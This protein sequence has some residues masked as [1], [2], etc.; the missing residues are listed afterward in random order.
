MVYN[1]EPKRWAKMHV[2]HPRLP[3]EFPGYVILSCRA[4]IITPWSI[5]VDDD[6]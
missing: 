5:V 3:L 4:L 2:G 6:D 1:G